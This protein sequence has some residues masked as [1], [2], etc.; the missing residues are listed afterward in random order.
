MNFLKAFFASCLGTLVA[1]VVL[2]VVGV[3]WMGSL[4]AEKEVSIK[5]N[6][7]LHLKLDAPI[8]ELDV[9]DPFAELFPQAAEQN[10]GLL[11][12]KQT[13]AYA[14]TDPKIQGIYLNVSMA[15]AG[16]ATLSEIRQSLMRF[17]QTGKWVI[18][19]SDFYSEGAYYLASAADQVFLN[20]NGLV[21][22]N[23]LST[24][25]TFFQ[26]LFEKLDIRPQIFR[27]GDF[28]SA[29]EP[30]LRSDLSEENKLQL[31]AMLQSIHAEILAGISASRNISVSDLKTIADKMLVRNARQALERKL[32]DSLYYDDQVKDVL[33]KKLGLERDKKI[34]FARYSDYR[35]TA[36]TV[37]DS[38]NEIAVVVADGDILPGQSDMGIVGSV[39]IREEIRKARL[40]KKVK[41]IV[42]RINSPG[43]SAQASD[44]MWREITL[45]AREK[46]VI[47]SMSDYAA[48]GG[49]YLA[50]GCDSI[51]AQ[52][53]T[54]TGSIGVFSVLFDMSAFLSN[55]LGITSEEV[56]TGEV[57]E[58]ITVTRA[59]T[60]VEKEIWQKQ[61]DEIYETFTAKAAEGRGVTQADIKK[62]AS[63]RVWTGEQAR[64]NGLVDVEGGFEEAVK[65]A[66]AKAGIGEDYKLR[67][68]PRQKTVIERLF[69]TSEEQITAW[70]LKRD[71]G[72]QYH[73]YVQAA[74]IKNYQ[75]VQARLPF[76]LHTH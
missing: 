60:P 37:S 67:F 8:T 59:L 30:F 58:L 44:D 23:G 33:R 40:S 54:I 24:E 18:A 4:A 5:D 52:P 56:K 21:E 64:Q 16:Y 10:I 3:V 20:P 39:T 65:I 61:T 48:S 74:K 27:V 63:G 51:V 72:D 45:A 11:P 28:K 29:V 6:S 57:G 68:Y 22:F 53:A 50:M 26:R 15:P 38:K 9:E 1:L 7:V 31:N 43:G 46:P 12:L 25:V 69:S 19:Y 66:A 73:W 55:K 41:A 34:A 47:A 42:L 49:Y 35:K 70:M 2:V 76:Q 13:L 36:N 32:V 71:L 17:R 75:G 14:E 62:V